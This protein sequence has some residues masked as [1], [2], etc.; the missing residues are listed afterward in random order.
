MSDVLKIPIVSVDYIQPLD[1]KDDEE[2]VQNMIHAVPVQNEQNII[3]MVPEMTIEQDQRNY[4][5]KYRLVSLSVV[6]CCFSIIFITL[7]IATKLDQSVQSNPATNSSIFK[8][9]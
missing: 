1:V 6:L 5:H 9:L 3:F 7:N 4:Q 8:L 2:N